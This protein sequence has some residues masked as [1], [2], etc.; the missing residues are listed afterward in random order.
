MAKSKAQREYA[1][2]E[3]VAAITGEFFFDQAGYQKFYDR[4]CDAIGGITGVWAELITA[5][6]I[7]EYVSYQF[8]EPGEAF[9][10]ICAV[11][12]YARRLHNA[13]KLAPG[14]YTVMAR[15]VLYNNLYK[16]GGKRGKAKS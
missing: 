2:L 4:H 10:W 15:D 14:E 8:G 16:K 9:D 12:D 5:A 3:A 11:Q 6:K 13:G 1:M 7:F